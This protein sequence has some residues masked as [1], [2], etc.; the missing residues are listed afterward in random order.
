MKTIIVAM[1]LLL[2]AS[3]VSALSCSGK[4]VLGSIET[5]NLVD[6]NVNLEAKLDTGAD[7]T[8][9][10]ATHIRKFM[11]NNKAWVQFTVD[12][13]S[14]HKSI[15]FTEP[16]YGYTHILKRNEENKN[17][18]VIQTGPTSKRIV[19][20]MPI[21]IGNQLQ[22]ILV[23][24]TDRSHFQ[25]PMLIGKNA[26]EKLHLIVDVSQQHLTTPCKFKPQK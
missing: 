26:M 14:E 10:S 21:C 19:V 17:Q 23:N 4:Q 16:F 20:L 5:V 8:S 18:Q 9:L 11:Q 1:A 22:K 3:S 13:P 7:M 24:L 6:K 2:T 25:Y 15:S 12:I